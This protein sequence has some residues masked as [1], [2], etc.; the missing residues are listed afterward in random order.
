M[1]I[2]KH[3]ILWALMLT[4]ILC[5]GFFVVEASEIFSSADTMETHGWS[6][7]AY[8]REAKTQPVV[9]LTG[10]NAIQVP[11]TGGSATVFS[12]ENADLK[13]DQR[14]SE[15]VAA[16]D[17]HPH[18]GLT[19]RARIGQIQDFDLEFSSGSQTNKL[20]STKSGMVWGLGVGGGIAP[21]SIVSTAISWQLQFT[22][23]LVDL[24]RLQGGP[25]VYASDERFRQD[26]FQGSVNFSRRWKMWEPYAGLKIMRVTSRLQDNATKERVSGSKNGVS[27]FVGL[28]V[29]V[30][31]KE[32]LVIEGSF[33]DEKSLTAG[34]K[35]QF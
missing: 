7:S 6:V 31:E 33:V 22:Q 23:R 5:L 19:Y 21:G 12:N 17:F 25:V 28:Q 9:R 27:P 4:V 24:D 15:V 16:F 3:K 8:G 11:V 18:D 13:M 29:G 1:K 14:V 2:A 10:T 20:E 32:S 35:L 26:E 30:A 34:I